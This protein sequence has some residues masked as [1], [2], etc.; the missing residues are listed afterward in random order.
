MSSSNRCGI[1]KPEYAPL[2]PLDQG[3]SCLGGLHPFPSPILHYHAVCGIQPSQNGTGTVS[4]IST[5]PSHDWREHHRRLLL[6]PPSFIQV[7][8]R[9]PGSLGIDLLS[10]RH[11][12]GVEASDTRLRIAG[13]NKAPEIGYNTG[14]WLY[15][16]G[17]KTNSPR[18]S[19]RKMG[20]TNKD[21]RYVGCVDDVANFSRWHF[22][23]DPSFRI[24]G[25][26]YCSLI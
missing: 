10:F 11:H 16:R 5:S 14:H 7:W 12:P 19:V 4:L 6:E 23:S 21:K 15:S 24:L 17:I 3:H 8:G 20:R 25:G 22:I 18:R 9:W 2:L 13:N 26:F 1:P